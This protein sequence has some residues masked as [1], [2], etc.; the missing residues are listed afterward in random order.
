MHN[1]KGLL[2]P[3]VAENNA[4]GNITQE[5]QILKKKFYLDLQKEGE[6]FQ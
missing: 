4:I 6:Q 2:N 3:S 5:H 1:R